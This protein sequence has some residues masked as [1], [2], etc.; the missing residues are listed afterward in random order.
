MATWNGHFDQMVFQSFVKSVGVYPVGSLVR[1]RSGRLAVVI[2][3]NPSDLTRP[4]VKV[5]FSTKAGLP[6]EP[7]VLDLAVM[8]FVDQ[9]EAHEP[10]E[11]WNFPYLTELWNT[12]AA[13]KQ[14]RG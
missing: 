10:P 12:E 14:A 8:H 5:F 4:R 2:E 3:Q 1:M 7:R 11:K 9:I 6:L 13:P